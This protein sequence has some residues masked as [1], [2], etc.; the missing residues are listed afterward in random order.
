MNDDEG[1]TLSMVESIGLQPNH[2]I[3]EV[4]RG[5]E[6]LKCEALSVN[7]KEREYLNVLKKLR[8]NEPI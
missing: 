3:I 5:I 6:A 7:E 2:I 1:L 8:R 4:I